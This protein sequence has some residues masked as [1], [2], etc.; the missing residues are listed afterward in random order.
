MSCGDFDARALKREAQY[1]NIWIPNYLKRWIN[2]KKAF[3]MHLFNLD[4]EAPDFS[5]PDTIY[6][7]RPTVKGMQDMLQHVCL[8]FLGRPHSGI[9]DSKNIAKIAIE[10]LK[11]DDFEFNQGMVIEEPFTTG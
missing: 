9:D 6:N 7:Q 10:L 3:P 5:N 4:R 1:K 2:I 8:N 11:K